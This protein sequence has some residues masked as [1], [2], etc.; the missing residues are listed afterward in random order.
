MRYAMIW[1]SY[2]NNIAVALPPLLLYAA[3]YA[4]AERVM[5]RAVYTL[6]FIA[7][8]VIRFL[9]PYFSAQMP[10]M[11]LSCR[12]YAYAYAAADFH[13]SCRCAFRR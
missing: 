10:L 6:C 5:A 7:T 9:P 11:S 2:D 1:I 13:F 3:L 4:D 12:Y 8:H